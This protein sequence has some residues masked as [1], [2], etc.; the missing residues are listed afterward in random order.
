MLAAAGKSITSIKARRHTM[1]PS[2][3]RR[4]P[5]ILLGFSELRIY[6]VDRRHVLGLPITSTNT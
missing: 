3:Y 4:S 6:I 5:Y 2:G 1:A